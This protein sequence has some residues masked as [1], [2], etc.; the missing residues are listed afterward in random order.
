MDKVELS[1]V[2]TV[3]GRNSIEYSKAGGSNRQRK[4][5]TSPVPVVV[6]ASPTQPTPTAIIPEATNGRV[7]N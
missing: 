3:Y 4:P 2:A 5:S 7:K 1:G 6:E